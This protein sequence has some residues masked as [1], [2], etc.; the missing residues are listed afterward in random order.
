[1]RVDD[2]R[3]AAGEDPVDD[4]ASEQGCLAGAGGADHVH[5]VAGVRDGE[6]DRVAAD[7]GVAEHG[8]PAAAGRY[9]DRGGHR[10]GAGPVE[11]GDGQVLRQ[12]G[13]RGQFRQGGEEAGAEPA[14]GEHRDR[15]RHAGAV[16]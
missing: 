8:D 10:L 9:G 4:H 12:R 1:V 11:A 16:G 5:V 6:G 14:G 3:P 7:L 13:E 2:H 15:V